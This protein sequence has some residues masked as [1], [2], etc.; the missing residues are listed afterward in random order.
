MVARTREQRQRR[1]GLIRHLAMLVLISLFLTLLLVLVT[2]QGISARDHSALTPLERSVP[3][4]VVPTNTLP[5]PTNTPIPDTPT[6]V[7]TATADLPTATPTIAQSA[8]DT[9]AVANTPSGNG[10][11]AADPGPTS[12]QSTEVVLS[13]PTVSSGSSNPLQGLSPSN[14]GTN[15]LLVATTLGCIVGLLGIAVGGIALYKLVQSGYGP[16][17]RALALGNR[18]NKTDRSRRRRNLSVSGRSSYNDDFAGDLSSPEP[19]R[20]NLGEY[21]G[22]SGNR[23][24]RR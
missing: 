8:T 13:Q 24:R 12:P 20:T 5:V 15:G 7:P 9:P 23:G 19:R 1:H 4:E 6:V 11:G 18:R 16:F 17:L 3:Q 21:S 2:A 22:S 14:F 10:G